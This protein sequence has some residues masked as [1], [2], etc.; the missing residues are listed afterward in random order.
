MW[1]TQKAERAHGHVR[2]LYDLYDFSGQHV[3]EQTVSFSFLPGSSDK[4]QQLCLIWD[5]NELFEKKPLESPVS[6][7]REDLQRTDKF[8]ESELINLDRFTRS[9]NKRKPYWKTFRSD[10]WSWRIYAPAYDTSTLWWHTRGHFREM[11]CRLLELLLWFIFYGWNQI[12]YVKTFDTMNRHLST[13]RRRLRQ[14]PCSAWCCG[15]CTCFCNYC[16]K[17]DMPGNFISDFVGFPT[18]SCYYQWSDRTC[19]NSANWSYRPPL[20]HTRRWQ[21]LQ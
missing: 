19:A 17:L 16:Y 12:V 11:Y 14:T 20:T 1:T 6:C 5:H 8:F 15:F 18:F 21:C 13:H 4:I 9:A 7:F 2:H 10:I 3:G